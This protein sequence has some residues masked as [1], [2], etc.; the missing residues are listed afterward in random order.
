MLSSLLQVAST[1]RLTLGRRADLLLEIAALRQQLDV[2]RRQVNRPRLQRKDRVFWIWLSRNWPKWKDALV[3]VQPETVL[4]WHREGYRRYWRRRSASVGRPRIPWEHIRFI[5]RISTDHPEWG[6]DRIALELKLKLGIEHSPSTVRRYMV[7]APRPPSSGTWRT[8]LAGHASELLTMDFTTQVLWDFTSRHVLVIMK[9]E[10]R[11]IV[12]MGITA[13]PTLAWV[14]QQVREATPWDQCPRFLLHDND[15]IFGQ[16]GQSTAGFRC[17]LDAWLSGVMG[18]TGVPIPFGAPNAQAHIERFIGTLRRE[19]LR[20]F[21]F[22]S[23]D[24]LRRTVRVFIDY[25]NG[26]RPHQGIGAIPAELSGD[27][28][29]EGAGGLRSVDGKPMRLVARPI[30][31]GLV[32][33]YRLAA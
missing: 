5:K 21:I 18:I 19:C 33:D 9:L 15:G 16:Y 8:F 3:I 6:E 17:S 10:T 1:L 25:Y 31:G 27:S 29:G 23:E 13:S 32:H 12:H 22:L 14:K 26:C 20:H 30:L 28:L 4:R 2:L 7:E 11:E 24:H